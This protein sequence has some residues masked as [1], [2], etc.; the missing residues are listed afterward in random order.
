MNKLSRIAILATVCFAVL[1]SMS[2]GAS[3]ITPEGQAQLDADWLV[4]CGGKP[5]AKMVTDEIG[6]AREL[7]AR[8]EKIKGCPS[9]KADL[10]KL[11]ELEKQI[12][13]AKDAEAAKK[14]YLAVR[15]AKRKI[16]FAN[17]L[18]NFDKIVLIDNPFPN[19]KKGDATNEWR[20]EARHRNGYMAVMG[21][22]L[23]SVGLDPGSKATS[24]FGDRIG[25]FWRPDVHFNG[26]KIVVSFQPTG[27]K[28]FHLYEVDS[29]GKNVKQLT[30]GDYDDLDPIYTPDNHITFCSSRAHTYVRCMPM[31]HAYAVSRCDAD[32]KNIYV[33]SRNGEAEYMAS[34]LND[35]R[36]I[37]TRWEYTEKALWRIQSLWTMNPDGTNVQVFWGNQSRWPDVLTEARAIPGSNRVMFTGLG[38]HDWFN[39]SL[40]IIDPAKGLNYPDGL[41]KVTPE[42]RWTEVGDGPKEK[43][44]SKTYHSCKAFRAYKTP[45]P[46]SEEDFLCSAIVSGGRGGRFQL[47]LMDIHGNRELIHKGNHNAYYA[48]P[49]VARKAPPALPDRVAWPKI[50]SGQKAASGVLYSNDVFSNAPKILKEK[51]KYI[52]SVVMDPK[53]YTTWHKTVQHDGPAVSVFQAD[54]VKRILGT[55]PIEKDGSICMEIPAGIAVSFQVLDEKKQCI[56]VMRSFT[57]VMPGET[58]GC[59]GC[60]ESKLST[61]GN[62]AAGSNSIAM[63]KGPKK[64]VEPAWGYNTSISYTRFVQPVLDKNCGKCHQDPKHKAFAKLNMTYRPSKHR[65]RTRVNTRPD[66][67]SPFTEPYYTLVG[68]GQGWG[69]RQKKMPLSGVYVVES[70]NSGGDGSDLKTLPP[71]SAFSPKSTLIKNAS[72]GEHHKVKVSAADLA[73]LVAWVDLNGPY[74]GDEEIRNMYDP[75]SYAAENISAVRPRVATAPMIDRFNIRQDGD[76]AKVS[77]PLKLSKKA[78]KQAPPRPSKSPKKPKT[79][80]YTKILKVTYGAGKN[81]NDVTAKVTESANKTGIITISS[82]HNTLF[83]DPINGTVKELVITFEHKGKKQTVKALRST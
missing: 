45:Y 82:E 66:D 55:T 10:A 3:A 13:G 61:R 63:K 40:G 34:V 28:S 7:A 16:M 20:H 64:P 48:M 73:M 74:L 72:S 6:W 11:A 27:H 75:I 17:P 56:H 8:L 9:L 15:A 12:A 77:G 23:L 81:V 47:Y 52:R 69:G 42:V 35:G 58:R 62:P 44:E 76:S 31:T 43:T 21:G 39:G 38:H 68:G 53:S 33:V 24:L 78:I 67:V 59:F 25:S 1:G 29:E 79:L 57:G 51:G 22:K 65:W 4:Q 19:G 71:Y 46:L 2:T 14:L 60:H 26:K 30:F 18:I 41:T 50:G 36:V 80:V 5:T 83:G 49:L 54:G 32:G 37:Y 70:Y